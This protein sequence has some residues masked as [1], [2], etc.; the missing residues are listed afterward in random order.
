MK[1]P[2]SIQR[3]GGSK[4]AAC[5][6]GEIPTAQN[7][8]S[9]NDANTFND[10]PLPETGKLMATESRTTAQPKQGDRLFELEP[11][12][13]LGILKELAAYRWDTEN[14]TD[15]GLT[16]V[17]GLPRL[18]VYTLRYSELIMLINFQRT[19]SGALSPLTPPTTNA[20][21]CTHTGK[22]VL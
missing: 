14:V 18:G 11:K 20:Y 7:D 2:P 22:T 12:T 16:S 15:I 8:V 3:R 10:L 1:L 5:L 13:S 21:Q 9:D 17:H 4:D 19:S 6:A